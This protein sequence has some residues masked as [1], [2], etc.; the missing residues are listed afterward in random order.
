MCPASAE[1]LDEEEEE[2]DDDDA[3]TSDPNPPLLS[4]N[5]AVEVPAPVELPVELPEPVELGPKDEPPPEAA[6]PTYPAKTVAHKSTPRPRPP[7]DPIETK[8]IAPEVDMAERHSP[9]KG[10]TGG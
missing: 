8:R 3:A 6:H 2:D 1:S 9:P 5:T 10:C 4:L 7:C